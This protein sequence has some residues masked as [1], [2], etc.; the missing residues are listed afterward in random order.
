MKLDLDY[1]ACIVGYY[2]FLSDSKFVQLNTY[3]QESYLYLIPIG[4]VARFN[5]GEPEIC[6]Q[7]AKNNLILFLVKDANERRKETGLHFV[8]ESH[9][10]FSKTKTLR[11][12]TIDPS[13]I[14][15]D[16]DFIPSIKRIRASDKYSEGIIFK[17]LLKASDFDHKLI[18]IESNKFVNAY[19]INRN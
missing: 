6:K 7:I 4:N 8:F 14:H 9:G 16:G 18:Q 19:S 17:E 10:T 3:E 5:S 1:T 12:D 2:F 15:C 13:Y 11:M